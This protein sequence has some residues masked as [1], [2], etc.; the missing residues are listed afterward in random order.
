MKLK[1]GKQV[2]EALGMAYCANIPV[3]L[4]G[5][6]GIGK[7]QLFEQAAEELEVDCIV[8]DLSLMEPPD[9]VGLPYTDNGRT[10]YAPPS[11]LPSN[12]QGLL[13]FEELNRCEK[14]MLAPCL[15]LL[16][17]RRLNDY[18]LPEGWLPVAAINPA[19]DAY[20]VNEI[21]PALLSRFT[22][23]EAEPSVPDFLA[24]AKANGVHPA[25]QQ[26]VGSVRDVFGSDESNPRAW[27]HL[28][29][30]LKASEKRA[31]GGRSVLPA[32]VAGLVGG[33]HANAF[34]K[35]Y[36]GTEA[37]LT[38]NGILADPQNS[39]DIV[40]AWKAG[41]RTD[42]LAATAHQIQ[43]ALQSSD[44]CVELCDEPGKAKVLRDVCKAFP[45]DLASPIRARMKEQGVMR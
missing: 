21:D 24:W 45:A 41:K 27:T 19:G 35:S 1:A 12:G 34:L 43:V 22:K 11:F 33:I 37:S 9:L 30:L 6:H 31:R 39:L 40:R 23:I 44:V 2:I 7:S 42:L 32:L 18:V 5:R 29:D 10:R 16:T 25:V 28:S 13:V 8:R 36:R 15:Q 4:I 26:Y 14:Y 38:L 20:D 3:M 17:A